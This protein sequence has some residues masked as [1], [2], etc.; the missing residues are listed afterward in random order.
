MDAIYS[1]SRVVD[2]VREPDNS[3]N[4]FMQPPFS[5][6]LVVNSSDGGRYT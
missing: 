4:C 2:V 3:I 6:W 1:N 5:R